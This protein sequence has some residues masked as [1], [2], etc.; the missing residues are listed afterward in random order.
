MVEKTELDKLKEEVAKCLL[1]TSRSYQV[2]ALGL[3]EFQESFNA[4]LDALTK[5]V[6]AMEQEIERLKKELEKYGQNPLS[7]V[8][9]VS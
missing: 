9:Q 2:A 3:Q 1:K 4:S 6:T 7:N 5:L 8:S